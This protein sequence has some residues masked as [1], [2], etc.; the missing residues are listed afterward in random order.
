MC[1]L[2]HLNNVPI[3]SQATS[4]RCTSLSITSLTLHDDSILSKLLFCFL[5]RMFPS[6]SVF[7][8]SLFDLN[9]YWVHGSGVNCNLRLFNEHVEGQKPDHAF[10]FPHE[11]RLS[12]L[13]CS[14][15]MRE[16][17]AGRRLSWVQGARLHP[18]R[19]M[20]TPMFN[21]G[22][23]SPL[24]SFKVQVLI[25]QMHIYIYTYVLPMCIFIRVYIYICMYIYLYLYIY[26]Y[27][28]K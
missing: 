17:W 2:P 23:S 22:V 5:P 9:Y 10:F 14:Q 25:G 15:P 18:A 1:I 24:K 12:Q 8:D 19:M 6:F 11:P 3:I 27:V 26:I 7:N 13:F 28:C 21:Q 16:H 4:T 20:Q